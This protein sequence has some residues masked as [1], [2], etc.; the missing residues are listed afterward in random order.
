MT[1]DDEATEDV[2]A[3]Y[4]RRSESRLKAKWRREHQDA[5]S[6]SCGG[7][8]KDANPFTLVPKCSRCVQV[9]EAIKE[10]VLTHSGKTEHLFDGVDN[11]E[12]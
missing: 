2:Q 8:I 7:T 1:N 11:L 10:G 12:S 5:T 3:A 6:I 4:R 9:E